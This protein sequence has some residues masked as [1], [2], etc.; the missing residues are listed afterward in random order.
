MNHIAASKWQTVR[1]GEIA[2][3]KLGKMLDKAKHVNGRRLPYLRNI[4]VRWG[5]VD[6][7]DLLEMNFE[8]DEL[9]RFGLRK[10]DVLVCEGGE[11]GRAAVWNNSIPNMKYQ[12]AIH[13]IRF[14]Q[15]YE[16]RLLIYLLELLTK[17]GRLERRFTGSTIKHFTREAIVQL[18]IPVPPLDEQQRVVSEIEKQF[19]RLD[20]GVASLK[21]VQTALKR[22]RASVL[23]AACEGR[24]VPTE[25]ELAR[26]E[27][28]SYETGE[29]LLRRILKPRRTRWN[30]K[31]KYKEPQVPQALPDKLPGGWAW[32]SWDQVAFSQNGRPFKSAEYQ[33]SGFKLLRP[34]NL[35]MSGK[36][37]WTN[38]NTRYVPEHRAHE[39]RD[40][41]VRKRELIMNLTAQ[42]LRDEFL[43]RVCLTAKGEECLLNQ[44]LARLTPILIS[45]EFALYLL[46]AWHFRRF[47]DKLNTGSLIQHMFTS[48]L[49]EFTF[50]LPPFAEQ[51]RIVAEVERRLSVANEVDVELSAN[52]R[53]ATRLQQS[54][55]QKVFNSGS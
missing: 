5:S 25:A 45:P 23:K 34:G 22:Y 36:V 26:K 12:K 15:P 41:V 30:G 53:R 10:D 19:T 50:P 4:N 48:Q 28:R 20:A 31:G 21:R 3:V 54:I 2:E 27:N 18:P 11:P 42:S 52:L 32:A 29:Q 44:R 17:T 37:I 6:T 14:K 35:H 7:N 24:L 47:V 16:P 40:L 1:L 51:S 49:S 39:N 8:D 55:L 46:K 13:R 33:S 43:G 9:D 38:D